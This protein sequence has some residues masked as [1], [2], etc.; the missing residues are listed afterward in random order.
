MNEETAHKPLYTQTHLI[1]ISRED[2]IT[3]PYQYQAILMDI[4]LNQSPDHRSVMIVVH[5]TGNTGKNAFVKFASIKYGSLG[6]GSGKDL[7][8]IVAQNKKPYLFNLTK[9]APKFNEDSELYYA[10]QAI[11]D[12]YLTRTKYMPIVIAMERP[13]VIV[14]TNTV[15]EINLLSSD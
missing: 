13:H 1:H 12:G 2:A 14:F 10:L 8:H 9:N 7:L 5:K 11:K 15:T 4:I 3:G 6:L